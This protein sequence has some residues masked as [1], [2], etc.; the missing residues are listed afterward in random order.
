[1]SSQLPMSQCVAWSYAALGKGL[2]RTVLAEV[3]D[4][5]LQETASEP[6]E[7]HL[8]ISMSHLSVRGADEET[9]RGSL[10]YALRAWNVCANATERALQREPS[11]HLLDQWSRAVLRGEHAKALLGALSAG[12]PAVRS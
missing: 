4:V 2:H 6:A 9:V 11:Q 5:V 7:V 12:E 10:Q 8:E 3:L 1:M